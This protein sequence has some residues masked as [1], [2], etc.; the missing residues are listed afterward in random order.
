MDV[1]GGMDG[2]E[3]VGEYWGD[4]RLMFREESRISTAGFLIA[5]RVIVI[6]GVLR[7]VIDEFVG[8]HRVDVESCAKRQSK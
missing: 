5:V 6:G 1:K 4:V 8:S 2:I 3:K 7:D